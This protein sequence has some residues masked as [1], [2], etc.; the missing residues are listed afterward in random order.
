MPPVRLPPTTERASR[1]LLEG[2]IDYAGLFP[3]ASLVM[4]NAVRN[5]AHYRAS[6]AGWMLGRFICPAS[7]L[8][9]FSAA[10]DPL[11]P[12]DAGAIPWR[13]S[14]TGSADLSADLTQVAA[15]NERH[16][17]CFEECGARVDAIELRVAAIDDVDRIA[18]AVPADLTAYLEVPLDGD[19]AA[20]IAAIARVGR[21]AK[22]RTGGTTADMIPDAA[23]VVRF[24]SACLEHGVVA[25]AT[26]GLH[27]PVRGLYRLTYE[28]DAATGRMYGFLNMA[29][30]TALLGSGG[31]EREALLLLEES[32]AGAFEFN[33]LHVAWHGPDETR[34]FSRDV[35]Q[36]T[37]ERGMV[38]FGSCSFTEP[39]DESRALGWL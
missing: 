24:F 33:D 23:R 17:V 12:R 22:I 34:T 31:S 9:Q 36:Q 1:I 38:S 25:K 2:L 18:Q 6:G 21:R 35:L 29:L 4:S 27:H 7:S 26:A 28:A 11:L 19:I 39:V 15:F 10:A 37:R 3:P 8:E 20:Y 14:V 16:R 5:Y 32:D 30:V 13:L